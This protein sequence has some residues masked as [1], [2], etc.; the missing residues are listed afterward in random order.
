MNN[1]KRTLR[2]SR[3]AS[4]ILALVFLMFSVFV[5]GSVLA[6]ATANSARIQHQTDTQQQFLRQRS[7]G[8]AQ[9][10]RQPSHVCQTHTKILRFCVII[11]I[12]AY[13]FTFVKP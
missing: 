8:Q 9:Q 11:S 3:G 4:M 6:V 13:F 12:I 1:L 7:A 2:S 5:G 10:H